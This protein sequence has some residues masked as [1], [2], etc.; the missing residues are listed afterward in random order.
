MAAMSMAWYFYGVIAP[1]LTKS[2]NFFFLFKTSR[3]LSLLFVNFYKK[4]SNI[5]NE[6]NALTSKADPDVGN[7]YF[8]S[9]FIYFSIAP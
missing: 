3:Y 5:L 7:F 8:Y 1:F 4:S 6:V 9:Y 2:R